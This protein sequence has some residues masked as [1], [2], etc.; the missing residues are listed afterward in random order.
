M[1]YVQHFLQKDKKLASIVRE[2]LPALTLQKNIPLQLMRSIMGQQLSTKVADVIYQ[3]FLTLCGTKNP[4]PKK[5]LTL[6]DEALRNIGLSYAKVTYVKN[7]AAY[8]LEHSITD[9]ALA[10]HTED[11]IIELLLPIKG[12]GRWTIEMLLM[13]SL[14]RPNVFA[15][16]DLGI[17][18]AMCRLYKIDATDKKA[19]KQ[20]MLTISKKW[21]PYK[22]YAC[23]HLWQWKDAAK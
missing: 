17:Q 10:K 5:V 1:E 23:L 22:T 12:V 11:A 15:V 20:R 9:T 19:M 8:C 7:V 18:Q 2:P 16:D 4:S 21:E 3:R 6:S 14:A 13:F